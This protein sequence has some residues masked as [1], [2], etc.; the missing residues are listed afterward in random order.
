M[1]KASLFFFLILLG[2]FGSGNALIPFP[3]YKLI[4][5]T[6]GSALLFYI[7][8]LARWKHVDQKL[9]RLTPLSTLFL[10]FLFW[11][12][13]GYL[14]SATPE[15]SLL[16]TVQSLSAILVYLGLTLHIQKESQTETIL[17]TLLSFG[18][19][20]AFIGIIQ[21]F[22]LS[23]LDNPI[24][25]NNNSTS[26]FV[27][28]N[29]FAGYLVFLIPLSCLIYL[30]NFSKLW[31][32]IAGISFVLCLTA[33]IFSGSRGGQLVAILELLVIMGYLI[34]NTERKEAMNLVIGIVV[35]VTLYL[36]ITTATDS[37]V[38]LDCRRHT[39]YEMT[40]MNYYDTGAWGQSL[41]RILFWQGA[42]EIFKDHWLIGSGPLSFAMLFPKYYITVTPIINSQTL[43]SGAPPHAHNLFA[44]I[45]SDSGLI[46]IGLMLAFLAIFYFRVCQLFLH[47]SL[48]TQSTVF[49]LTLAVT[50]FLVHHMIEYNWL[51]S[52]FIFNFTIFIFLIDFIKRKHFSFEKVSPPGRIFYVV[53]VAGIFVFFLT[54]AS[55]IQLYKYQSAVESFSKSG[56]MHELMSL[57]AQAK[58]ICPRCDRPYLL[59]AELFLTR[60]NVNHDELFIRLAKNELLKGRK[61]NPYDPYFNAYLGQVLAIQGDYNQALRLF[62]EALK[63]NRTH[64]FKLGFSPTQLRR[65]DQTETHSR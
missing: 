59:L 20:I 40:A 19:V 36:I 35:S 29:V 62:K 2:F 3:V 61:L 23:F 30:S 64:K 55:S 46:G 63:F 37:C 39:L 32:G 31:K 14:Y 47:S 41:N 58:Q 43:V 24:S 16:L 15:K 9:I 10:L 21:Q 4:V 60:Y 6:A 53:P 1:V 33:L 8:S 38:L 57:A 17:Q 45:A 52:M 42:W 12:A 50:S 18:G 65:M 7:V 13:L 11:S 44:Q 51:G 5:L 54:V 49:F 22:P 27:H 34:F 28:K 25:L 56:S 48:K 26:L